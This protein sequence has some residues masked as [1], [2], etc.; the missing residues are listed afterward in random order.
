MLLNR[1]TRKMHHCYI[2]QETLGQSYSKQVLSI[3]IH[4]DILFNRL[5]DIATSDMQHIV[6]VESSSLLLHSYLS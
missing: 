5:Y 4:T 1:N 3:M 2:N 6:P